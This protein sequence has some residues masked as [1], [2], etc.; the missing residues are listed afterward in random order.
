MT[1]GRLQQSG[2]GE[3]EE[4]LCILPVQLLLGGTYAVLTCLRS[5]WVWRPGLLPSLVRAAGV[6]PTTSPMAFTR[7]DPGKVLPWSIK[8]ACWAMLRVLGERLS[9]L[10]PVTKGASLMG[11]QNLGL[12]ALIS[13]SL[14]LSQRCEFSRGHQARCPEADLS[15]PCLEER[16]S[17]GSWAMVGKAWRLGLPDDGAGK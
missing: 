5:P 7:Y 1:R 17:S 6:S 4:G 16:V 13:C 3:G 12:L 14:K 2:G 11:V 9:L 15:A 10:K 8:P